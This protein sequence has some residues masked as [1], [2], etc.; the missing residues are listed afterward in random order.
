M[1]LNAS[2]QASGSGSGVPI[3]ASSPCGSESYHADSAGESA[4]S[5]GRKR[6]S[7]ISHRVYHC[8]TCNVIMPR[9]S[10]SLVTLDGHAA[11]SVRKQ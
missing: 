7:A 9:M 3:M 6:I 8:V 1:A 5:N 11:W 10:R 2:V 4:G